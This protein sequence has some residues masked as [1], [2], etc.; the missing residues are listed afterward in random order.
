M[1]DTKLVEEIKEKTV[2]L[3]AFLN[4]RFPE[5]K[6]FSI[7]AFGSGYVYVDVGLPDGNTVRVSWEM[8][9]EKC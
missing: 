9:K 4:E 7:S 6:T 1:F 2:D 3:L 5:A 8:D